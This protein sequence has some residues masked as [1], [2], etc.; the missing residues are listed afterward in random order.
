[1]ILFACAIVAVAQK[2][3]A[4]PAR[5]VTNGRQDLMVASNRADTTLTQNVAPGDTVLHVAAT[6][7][8]V[9]PTLVSID[10]EVIYVCSAGSSTLAGSDT[11]N[12]CSAGRS[13]HS[14]A[15]ASHLAGAHV[16]GSA[17]SWYHDQTTAEIEA[18]ET[19]WSYVVKG[20]LK[21][22]AAVNHFGDSITCGGAGQDCLNNAL[23]GYDSSSYAN[24]Y[25]GL[26][27]AVLGLAGNNQGVS[28][29]QAAD[30][31]Q[32]VYQLN[33]PGA[34]PV[35]NT[36]MLGTNDSLLC[37][38]SAGCVSNFQQIHQ[39]E[40]AYL[41]LPAS[42]VTKA[43]GC[44]T[45]GVWANSAEYGGGM[46][47]YSSKAGSTLTCSWFGD[48]LYFAYTVSDGNTGRFSAATG[49]SAG[50][51]SWNSY[52]STPI[53]TGNQHTTRASFLT[54][55][56]GREGGP[57]TV[58]F[59]VTSSSGTVQID[60]VA[61]NRGFQGLNLPDVIVGGP[62]LM[63]CAGPPA[64]GGC[65]PGAIYLYN[66]AVQDNVAELAADGLNVFYANTMS[67]PNYAAHRIP[68]GIHP[69][70]AGHAAIASQFLTPLAYSPRRM[71][72]K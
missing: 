65:D 71:S 61:G 36:I 34:S 68:D 6:T 5:T 69:N 25:V 2:T 15:P 70:D 26:V 40:L 39:A 53:N 63:T 67:D 62:P 41:A 37:G 1:M 10:N 19:P 45:T 3:P 64:A 33:N 20:A 27:D 50:I 55:V 49:S 42:A 23:G 16:Q 66:Q 38:P 18:L 7:G 47:R 11:L 60:W 12:V 54:R 4:L 21:V 51:G 28:G 32:Y 29:S 14:A 43:Q 17:I 35:L 56:V 59:T 44:S 8:F 13:F 24:S 22:Y 57:H 31:Q 58:T 48:V 52:S 72:L 30:R 46:S 9:F